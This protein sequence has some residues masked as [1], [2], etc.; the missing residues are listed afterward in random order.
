MIVLFGV[1]NCKSRGVLIESIDIGDGDTYFFKFHNQLITSHCVQIQNIMRAA[2]IKKSRKVQVDIS[3]FITEYWDAPRNIVWFK[4]IKL[5]SAN[6]Q[7]SKT[8]M[9]RLNIDIGVKKRCFTI[10]DA[11]ATKAV[12]KQRKLEEKSAAVEKCFQ[13]ERAKRIHQLLEERR[14][15]RERMEQEEQE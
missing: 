7:I 11:K 6:Q 10:N 14:Q 13:E 3:E 5:D 2:D 12:E 15:A 1:R 4:G 8:M 9:K